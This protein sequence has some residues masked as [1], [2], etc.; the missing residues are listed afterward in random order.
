MLRLSPFSFLITPNHPSFQISSHPQCP[1]S[2]PYVAF[3]FRSPRIPLA[4]LTFPVA[5]PFSPRR[6]PVIPPSLTPHS[7]V[8]HPSFLSPVAHPLFPC[9]SPHP[10]LP[11][12]SLTPIS[13][14]PSLTSRFPVSLTSHSPPSLT[15]CFPHLLTLISPRLSPLI[16]RVAHPTFP[17]FHPPFPRHSPLIPPPP[18]PLLPSPV[19]F[20]H[21]LSPL[22]PVP[23]P[24]FIPHPSPNPNVPTPCAFLLTLFPLTCLSRCFPTAPLA[25]PHLSPSHSH[26]SSLSPISF[27]LL[28]HFPHSHLTSF[29]P[30]PPYTR[31]LPS[32][33]LALSGPA[34][35]PTPSQPFPVSSLFPAHPSFQLLLLP[36]PEGSPPLSPPPDPPHPPRCSLL[37]S[38]L[39]DIG[40]GPFPILIPLPSHLLSILFPLLPYCQQHC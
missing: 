16:P 23:H 33:G 22:I 24:L 6:S 37:I 35:F 9:R 27:L 5:H 25:S 36:R 30:P 29:H 32:S 21:P 39:S 26:R 11:L 3:P 17:P 13:F 20:P 34:K 7:P 14:P 38:L 4:Y 19:A 10:S 40:L 8:A 31:C 18:P 28:F 1:S 15:P 12:L 2:R